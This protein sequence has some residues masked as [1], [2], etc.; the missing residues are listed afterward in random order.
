MVVVSTLGQSAHPLPA[1]SATV[2]DSGGLV[3][4]NSIP[5]T[6]LRTRP[7]AAATV[8]GYQASHH[9]PLAAVT[10][11]RPASIEISCEGWSC[12]VEW[13][14]SSQ[15]WQSQCGW[16]SQACLSL[17]QQQCCSPASTTPPS[18]PTRLNSSSRPGRS[19]PSPPSPP[20]P[21]C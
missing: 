17:Q 9:Q 14:D 21:P 18:W 10:A 7:L 3:A 2:L 11:Q 20:S 19:Q 5:A 8:S 13:S 6:R 4:A 12:A 16:R 1:R 15:C